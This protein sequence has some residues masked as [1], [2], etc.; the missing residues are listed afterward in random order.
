MCSPCVAVGL[1]FCWVGVGG[2]VVRAAVGGCGAKHCGPSRAAPCGPWRG[3]A[4]CVFLFTGLFFC[5]PVSAACV[6]L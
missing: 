5:V 1:A 3:V 6:L 2:G 4:V